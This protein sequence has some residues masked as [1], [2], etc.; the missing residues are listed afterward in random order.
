MVRGLRDEFSPWSEVPNGRR[1][2]T[3]EAFER[4]PIQGL[5][6]EDIRK[7]DFRWAW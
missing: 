4:A 7:R 3:Q 2:E 5:T 6:D 1:V